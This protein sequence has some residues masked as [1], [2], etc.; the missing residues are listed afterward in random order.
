[1]NFY[2]LSGLFNAIAATTLGFFI[3]SRAP[4]NPK[5][6]TYAL[7][8]LSVSIW[9]YF[10]FAWQ[11]TESRDLALL[12]V[13]LLMAGAVLIPIFYFH[14]VLILLDRVQQHRLMLNGG[15]ALAGI[16][17]VADATPF[18]VRDLQPEMAFPYWPKPGALFH[19]FLAWFAGYAVYSTYLIAVEY[20]HATVLRRNQ[21]LYLAIGSII[22]YVG[23]ATN[24]PL[25]Y[26]VQIPPNGTILVSVYVSIIAYTMLQYRLL[27][28]SIAVEKG[29]TY[30]L[31]I[32]LVVLPAYAVLL[33]AQRAYFGEISYP[34]SA[35]AALLFSL[36]VLAGYKMKPQAQAAV[37]RILFKSRYDMY[38]TLST[39]SKALVSILDLKTLTEEIVRTLVAAMG[40]RAVALYLLDKE[41]G[42]YVPASSHGLQWEDVLTHRL[43]VADPL[44]RHVSKIQALVVREELEH[45]PGHEK[46]APVIESL[47]ALNADVC[48]PFINKNALV[49]FCILGSRTTHRMYSDQ[50]LSLLMTLAQAAAIALDNAVLY[51]E[52]KRSQTLVRRADRLRSLE[53]IAGGFAHEVRN[54]LTS[55]KTFIQL[56]PERK[57]D[58]EFIGHFS[59]VVAEDVARIERLIQEILDYARYM[60][61]K[62]MEEDINDIVESC[63]YFVRIKADT[64]SVSL[65]TDLARD[66]PPVTLDRQQI[67]QVLLNLL[68]NAIE[69]MGPAGGRLIVKTHRLA[70]PGGNSWV[71]VEITDTGC[72]IA[73]DDLDHIF[74]PFYTTKHASDEREGTGL[75]LTIVHQ[76]VQEHGGHI[77][78]DSKVGRGTTFL[79]S[80]PINP[81]AAHSTMGHA[82]V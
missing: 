7:F 17:L 80:L 63:L 54:P 16:F 2:A 79:V 37:G 69:A 48:I 1:M 66:L 28:F 24:F 9:S 53:T 33:Q 51:E 34:F 76:I 32:T 18:M 8:C 25:W 14:H 58:P 60:E 75:G 12:F 4:R 52:L 81:V 42:L 65:Q 56:T 73:P 61:P 6:Q 23:G 68:L 5:H 47:R 74:D 49:G 21:Y 39:F 13:R 29:L 38:E 36:I 11:L 40:I 30:L 31:L 15:Y 10:Y 72:G 67:K 55:I 20:R 64:K 19:V 22:G 71:Q 43:T 62:F 27:D 46:L 41:K 45:A 82:R 78:V 77:T 35:V 70:K 26:G 44:P 50:D 59:T 3:Y 57:D